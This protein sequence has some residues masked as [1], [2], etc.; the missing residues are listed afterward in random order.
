[1]YT[2][3]AALC[4]VLYYKLSVSEGEKRGRPGG[5]PGARR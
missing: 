2:L 1:M 5:G 3:H 4:A